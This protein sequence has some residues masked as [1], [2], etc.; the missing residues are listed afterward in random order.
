MS[1]IKLPYLGSSTYGTQSNSPSGY[2]EIQGIE[3]YNNAYTRNVRIVRVDLLSNLED[4]FTL[5]TVAKYRSVIYY[6]LAGHGTQDKAKL[7]LQSLEQLYKE[8]EVFKIKLGKLVYFRDTNLE[9]MS[10]YD[11]LLKDVKNSISGVMNDTIKRIPHVKVICDSHLYLYLSVS[12]NTPI[13]T[14]LQ[15]R[16]LEVISR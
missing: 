10:I 9:G 8:D 5:E 11:A 15:Y 16:G 1:L 6:I 14:L 3:Q 7:I 12:E 2:S 4:H 13:Q